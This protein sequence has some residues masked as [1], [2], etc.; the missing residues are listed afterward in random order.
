[1]IIL[2]R[3]YEDDCATDHM[4]KGTW[5]NKYNKLVVGKTAMP[6]LDNNMDKGTQFD[7]LICG[8]AK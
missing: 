2:W 7:K 5:Y 4:H 6:V 8:L 3:I 1:M